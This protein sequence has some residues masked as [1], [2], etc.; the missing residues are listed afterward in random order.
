MS[1]TQQAIPFDICVLDNDG[2]HLCITA[3]VNGT[4]CNLILDTG[5]SQTAF[6]I[7]F[8]QQVPGLDPIMKAGR[9]SSGLGTSSM[10]IHETAISIFELGDQ[11]FTDYTAVVVDLHH[12]NLTYEKLNMKPIHGVLG[13]DILV[14]HEAMIDY[15]NKQLWLR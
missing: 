2:Y 11:R 15:R 1:K 6:D 13:N 14:K 9:T 5:A 12:V 10:E 8:I 3:K 4:P 7:T